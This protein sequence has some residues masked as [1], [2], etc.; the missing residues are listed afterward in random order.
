MLLRS[1]EKLGNSPRS[2]LND[3]FENEVIKKCL[4]KSYKILDQVI[5]LMHEKDIKNLS[6]FLGDPNSI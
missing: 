3:K 6:T 4:C 1:L 2:E 5:I